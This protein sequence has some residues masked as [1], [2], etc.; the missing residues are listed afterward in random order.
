MKVVH[1]CWL[2]IVMWYLIVINYPGIWSICIGCCWIQTSDHLNI[3]V[4]LVIKVPFLIITVNVQKHPLKISLSSFSYYWWWMCRSTNIQSFKGIICL[5]LSYGQSAWS[6][7]KR[8]W[9][10]SAFKPA[11]AQN[12][13]CLGICV[14][15]ICPK[16]SAKYG[17]GAFNC[18]SC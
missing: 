9:L 18:F 6:I 17:P 15:D 13:F 12:F 8:Y 7:W 4:T 1:S 11:E 5:M 3:K 10:L 16:S 14:R 2:I